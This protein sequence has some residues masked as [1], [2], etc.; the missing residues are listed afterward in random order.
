[1]KIDDFQSCEIEAL[2]LNDLIIYNLFISHA[3]G[4]LVCL[5]R[6]I[7]EANVRLLG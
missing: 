4:M 1:M 6:E 7:F 2:K 3:L 5:F